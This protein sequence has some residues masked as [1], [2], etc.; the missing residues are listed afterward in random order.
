MDILLKLR[1]LLWGMVLALWGVIAYQFLG[2]QP[3]DGALGR[4]RWISNPFPQRPIPSS[5]LS[6]PPALV[7]NTRAP[8]HSQTSTPRSLATILQ[9]GS[10]PRRAEPPDG[11]A[12]VPRRTA[13]QSH[14][15]KP[16][17]TRP[18]ML[19]IGRR[20]VGEIVRP[21]EEALPEDE[22]VPVGFTRTT[23]RH[24]FVFSE[25]GP[26]GN[27]F[28]ET[29]ETLHGNIMLDLASFS[30][31]AR[32]ERVSIFLFNNQESYRMVT[33]RPAW[34]G[35]ASSVSKRKIYLYESEELIGILAH[36]LC[37]IYFDSFF[38]EKGS[39][40]PLWLSEGMATL[41][42]IERGLTAP[43]WLP[44]N[45]DVLY[46][47]GGYSLADLMKVETTSGAKDDNVRLWYTQSYSV[48]RFLN[49]AQWKSSFYRFSRNLRDGLPVGTALY[50]AYGM[51]FNRIKAL[52]YAWRYDIETR[53]ITDLQLNNP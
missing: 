20:E 15:T 29:L 19:D 11:R 38:Q 4:M 45:L 27:K 42:Q 3:E 52:E 37:H 32:D 31:W 1:L 14:L 39:S 23:T 50:R 36:E 51:P 16:L 26:P 21:H 28:L 8:L 44:E 33:G 10:I 53:R 40:N 13:R 43:N 30:P 12:I 41:V 49:R 47:G 2:P 34:S 22:T 25:G 7:P 35:G 46:E 48:A 17:P 18:G 9:P 5:M 24:F 6:D